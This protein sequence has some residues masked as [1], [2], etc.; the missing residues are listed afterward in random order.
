MTAMQF[1]LMSGP[2]LPLATRIALLLTVCF[3]LIS[4]P[5]ARS[6]RWP[7]LALSLPVWWSVAATFFA[8]ANVVAAQPVTPGG[9]RFATAAGVAEAHLPA[10][11]GFAVVAVVALLRAVFAH[12]T[13]NAPTQL[14]TASM[15]VLP[16]SVVLVLD[17][18]FSRVL[19]QV[20]GYT[21]WKLPVAIGLGLA[22]TGYG[23][24]V[25]GVVVRQRRTPHDQSARRTCFAVGLVAL[26]IAV[27]IYI[28]KRRLELF[29]MGS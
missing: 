27:A 3:L 19:L 12:T 24:V 20:T 6:T 10:M 1:E 28:V 13:L 7:L 21:P 5:L 23:L 26:L 17:W 25:A 22:V 9:G 16:L 15:V 29:A 18:W 11:F 2:A 4:V 14:T 8:L